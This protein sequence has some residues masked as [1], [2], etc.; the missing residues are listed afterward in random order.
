MREIS[1]LLRQEGSPTNLSIQPKQIEIHNQSIVLSTFELMKR[2]G[3]IIE[4]EI[5]I[6]NDKNKAISQIYYKYFTAS[7]SKLEL[8]IELQNYFDMK[9]IF[10]DA[11]KSKFA[12]TST[13]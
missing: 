5:V 13:L 11:K 7:I 2:N 8:I 12:K 6:N 10:H 3:K 4:N 9:F 1:Q